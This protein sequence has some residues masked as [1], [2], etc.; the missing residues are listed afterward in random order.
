MAKKSSPKKSGSGE[1]Q[2]KKKARVHEFPHRRTTEGPVQEPEPP[3]MKKK[4]EK[5]GLRRWSRARGS[6]AKNTSQQEN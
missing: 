2:E 3:Y 5:P 1:T 4:L 6:G